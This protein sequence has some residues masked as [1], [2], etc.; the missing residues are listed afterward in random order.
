[1]FF[2][3]TGKFFSVKSKSSALGTGVLQAKFVVSA[4]K[5]Q[6]K[7]RSI[8][9][10]SK[11]LGGYHQNKAFFHKDYYIEKELREKQKID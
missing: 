9:F 8:Y 2:D 4:V 11:E 6:S 10:D 1:M 5:M 3:L 7:R